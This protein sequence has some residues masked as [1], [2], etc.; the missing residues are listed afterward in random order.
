MPKYKKRAESSY[1][2]TV[3]LGY[4]TEGKRKL[5]PV[6]GRSIKELEAKLADIKSLQNKGVIISDNKTTLKEWAQKWLTAYKQV[7]HINTYEMYRSIGKNI[8]LL[9]HRKFALIRL[10]RQPAKAR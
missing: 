3:T 7:Q 2:T 8:L 10:R 6:Y 1:C 9:R 5:K 4:D